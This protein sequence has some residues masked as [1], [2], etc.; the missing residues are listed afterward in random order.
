M[1]T[2]NHGAP[3]GWHA[4]LSLRF[5]PSNGKTALK[6]RAHR[7]PL[8]VQKPLYPEGHDL[9]HAVIL[10]PPGGIAGGDTLDMDIEAEAGAKAL[11]TT[12][13]SG[14]WY[15]A[16]G[17]PARQRVRVSVGACAALEWLPQETIFFD[18]VQATLTTEV[19]LDSEAVF[20]GLETFCLGRIAAGET[21]RQGSISISTRIE[22][23]GTL[24]WAEQG[25]LTG[26][27]KLLEAEPGLAG[28]PFNA[29][30]LATGPAM[31]RSVLDA[32]RT[33]P[34]PAGTRS[35]V[36][37]LPSGLLAARCLAYQSEPVREWFLAL[38]GVLRPL[39]LDRPAAVPRLWNT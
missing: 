22:R 3:A 27:S 19:K 24:L 10:H 26:G 12:P 2:Q 5:G 1:E 20:L 9:C 16:A 31:K 4:S 6:G 34:D 21:F 29:T 38:W 7:G 23:N 18:G 11:I 25:R 36:T 37:L 13:G 30:F 15:R 17:R 32:C 28:Y 8:R 39:L 33:V 14:K 35:G